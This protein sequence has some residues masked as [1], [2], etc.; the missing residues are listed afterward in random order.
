[1]PSGRR[2]DDDSLPELYLVERGIVTRGLG[3]QK[4]VRIYS[5]E[6]NARISR[7]W[8]WV[9]GSTTC[10]RGVRLT[11]RVEEM[12]QVRRKEGKLTAI[13]NNPKLVPSRSNFPQD[14]L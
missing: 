3:A 12:E 6:L 7:G 1:M 5:P 2:D 10:D 14:I 9:N 4:S 11:I 13:R 8:T